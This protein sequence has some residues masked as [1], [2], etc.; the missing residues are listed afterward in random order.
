ML[1]PEF[2]LN[3][4]W[5]DVGS[6]S[7]TCDADLKDGRGAEPMEFLF[8][9][10]RDAVFSSE[11]NVLSLELQFVCDKLSRFLQEDRNSETDENKIHFLTVKLKIDNENIA[12]TFKTEFHN[13]CRLSPSFSIPQDSSIK[14]P[15]IIKANNGMAPIPTFTL[16]LNPLTL[17]LGLGLGL[18]LALEYSYLILDP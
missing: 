18:G 17:G 8:G 7:I 16:T 4:Q 3:F 9:N 13:R 10:V 2:E 12:T 11:S 5:F 1:K 14:K 15:A 6:S